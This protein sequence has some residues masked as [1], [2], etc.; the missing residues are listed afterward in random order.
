MMRSARSR[1]LVMMLADL[2]PKLMDDLL[3]TLN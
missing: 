1:W 3:E 2:Q